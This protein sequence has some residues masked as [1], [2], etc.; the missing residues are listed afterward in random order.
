[1]R[2]ASLMLVVVL[3]ALPAF[4]DDSASESPMR[5][6]IEQAPDASNVP[7]RDDVKRREGA[8]SLPKALPTAKDKRAALNPRL[9][10]S[11]LERCR[12][13]SGKI[14]EAMTWDE[15]TQARRRWASCSGF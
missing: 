3:L 7:R 13:Q 9:P 2:N 8:T 4:A 1:M 14:W 11:M 10:D 15:Q 6:A 12:S 5:P